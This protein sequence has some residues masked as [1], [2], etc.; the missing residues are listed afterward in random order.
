MNTYEQKQE[1]RRERLL[2][3]A[4]RATAKANALRSATPESLRHDWAFITQPGR[5]PER[6]RMN[7]RDA[8]AAELDKLAAELRGRA[9]SVG[10]GGISSDDPDAPGKLVERIAELE[11]KRETMK[12]INAAHRAYAKN[13]ASLD[14]AKLTDAEKALVRTYVPQYSWEPHPIAPYQLSN[15]GANIKRLKDRLAGLERDRAAETTGRPAI[16]GTGFTVDED[17]DENRVAIRFEKR[18]GPDVVK[19][20]RG[21]GFVWSPTRSAWVRKLNNS[22]WFAAAQVAAAIEGK[23]VA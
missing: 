11:A 13:P 17:R 23:V 14:R 1:D 10:G 18:Q 5:I 6:E 8:R 16:T 3:A 19:V 4:D 12:R 9:A 15:L 7:R 21:H 20:L 2:A 22:A